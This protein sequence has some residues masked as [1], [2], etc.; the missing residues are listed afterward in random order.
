M[1][2]GFLNTKTMHLI[3]LFHCWNLEKHISLWHFLLDGFI[4]NETVKFG[5]FLEENVLG[6]ICG[7]S[8]FYHQHRMAHLP[9][10]YQHAHKFHHHL[11]GATAFDAG[12]WGWGMP[13]EFFFLFADL[14]FC[15]WA[16]IMPTCFNK[17]MLL[18]T[19]RTKFDH[20]VRVGEKD[21]NFHSD[22]HTIH[23]KNFGVGHSF[24][25]LDLYFST[26]S[27]CKYPEQDHVYIHDK[28]GRILAHAKGGPPLRVCARKNP[29][30][31]P[32]RPPTTMSTS[33]K[34]N[35]NNNN[36]KIKIKS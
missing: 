31:P 25:L 34:K 29:K 20:L 2:Y 12:M 15:T 9:I 11:Q 10:I 18:I 19:F 28:D 16:G 32:L 17:K 4:L 35:K 27:C 3:I 1:L 13:E 5:S 26:F 24:G 30:F 23:S 6:N 22:H 14:F 36:I 21:D 33:S 7:M 8:L